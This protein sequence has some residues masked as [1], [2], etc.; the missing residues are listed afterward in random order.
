MRWITS[1]DVRLALSEEGDPAAPALRA[2]GGTTPTTIRPP[3][4]RPSS[5]RW[6]GRSCTLWGTTGGS[7]QSWE[8][9]GRPEIRERIASFTSFGG[10]GSDQTAH[11]MRYGRRSEVAGQL[12]RAVHRN[13]PVVAVNAEGKVGYALSRISPAALRRLARISGAGEISRLLNKD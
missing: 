4:W 3:T 11:F 8:L 6:A 1:G 2:T 13:Q 10:P 12:L 5:T 9:L 7:V